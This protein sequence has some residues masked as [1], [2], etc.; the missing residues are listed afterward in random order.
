MR[1][2]YVQTCA[3]QMNRVRGCD[4]VE[5]TMYNEDEERMQN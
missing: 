3:E 1:C 5:M 4:G 2:T